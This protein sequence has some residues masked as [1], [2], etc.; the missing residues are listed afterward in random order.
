VSEPP[1]SA[2]R[3]P[4]DLRKVL[5]ISRAMAATEDLDALLRL[6][7]ERSMELLRA[8]RA[9]VFLY[10]AQSHELVSRIAAGEGEIRSPADRG[11]AGATIRHGA[12]ILVAD[13][14]ADARFNPDVDRKTG[15]RTR[16][17]LSVPLRDYHGGL[18]GVLQ[19]LNKAGG[20]FDGQDVELGEVLAA[21]AGVALQRARLIDHFLQK[22]E[23]E[24]AMRIARDIQQ[25]LLPPASPRI[26]GY[27]VA[28]FCQPADETGGDTYDF[29]AL[30]DGRWMVTVADATGHGIGPA[31]VIAET[32][33]MLRALS[34]Y[35]RADAREVLRH[36]NELLAADLGDSRFVTCFLGLLDPLWHTVSYASAG[37]GPLLF[38]RRAEDAFDEVAATALPLGVFAEAPFDKLLAWR[39]EKGDFAVV[40][41]DGF[42]E[43]ANAAEEPFGVARMRDLLRRDRDLPAE[44]MIANLHAAVQEFTA[45]RPAQDDL[46]AIVIRRK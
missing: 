10:D 13:A 20:A 15:F 36:V 23:M 18:V 24:R 27:D 38:Y 32:R 5:E 22:Q 35:G 44:R 9:T 33:A 30:P 1:A 8:E 6:I 14:Y 39:L 3:P 25:G 42:F 19:V 7:V 28:G 29:L 17:I 12:T 4:P 31:L 11:V 16:N 41:T 40:T 43:A 2:S 34:R 45:C 21:Q 26:C 46:T 37:H